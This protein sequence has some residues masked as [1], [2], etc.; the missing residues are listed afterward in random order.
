MEYILLQ[1]ALAASAMPQEQDDKGVRVL[2]DETK[3]KK[4]NLRVEKKRF[5]E[6]IPKMHKHGCV[7][8]FKSRT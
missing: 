1:L 6:K 8:C 7:K 2:V 3:T 5:Q 4:K